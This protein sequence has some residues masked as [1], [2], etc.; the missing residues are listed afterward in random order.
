M[1]KNVFSAS[2]L[3]AKKVKEDENMKKELFRPKYFIDW[4]LQ[5]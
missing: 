2:E 3:K 1:E 4:Q 5:H